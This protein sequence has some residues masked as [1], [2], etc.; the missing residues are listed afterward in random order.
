MEL[1]DDPVLHFRSQVYAESHRR[2]SQEDKPRIKP[3]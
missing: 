1:S 2:R 3:E